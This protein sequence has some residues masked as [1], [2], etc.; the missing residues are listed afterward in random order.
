MFPIALGFGIAIVAFVVAVPWLVRESRRPLRAPVPPVTRDP[1]H[2][3]LS[4]LVI[5]T[6]SL[7][8][9]ILPR[10]TTPE[11]A[12]AAETWRTSFVQGRRCEV[13]P[14]S[15]LFAPAP[16]V[17]TA[18]APAQKPQAGRSAPRERRPQHASPPSRTGPG[19][20][21]KAQ[22]DAAAGRTDVNGGARTGRA[23]APRTVGR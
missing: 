9:S 7:L 12:D 10:H 15:E 5:S 8:V 11:V 2:P 20:R 17:A 22:L 4:S 21:T 1:E 23:R 14:R 3:V 16:G 6:R 18:R 19:G 13:R